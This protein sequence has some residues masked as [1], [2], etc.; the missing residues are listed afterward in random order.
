MGAVEGAHLSKI[1]RA[2]V[3]RRHDSS[4]HAPAETAPSELRAG[5][6]VGAG[7]SIHVGARRGLQ[8]TTKLKPMVAHAMPASIK[9]E[10]CRAEATCDYAKHDESHTPRACKATRERG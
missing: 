9:Q 5:P 10:P 6:S 4:R 2:L 7:I 8:R 3:E 1:V